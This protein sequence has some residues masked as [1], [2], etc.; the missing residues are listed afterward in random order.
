MGNDQGLRRQYEAILE[1]KRKRLEALRSGHQTV[2]ETNWG[3]LKGRDIT[4]DAI[5]EAEQDIEVYERILAATIVS[6]SD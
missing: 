5:A 2:F 4:V 1:R 3:G 6:P